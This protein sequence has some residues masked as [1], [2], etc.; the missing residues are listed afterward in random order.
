MGE[1]DPNL[2][3][4]GEALY[5]AGDQKRGIPAW[6]ACHGPTGAGNGPANFPKV[7]GQNPDHVIAALKEYQVGNRQQ[8]MMV[9]ISQKLN[10]KD[11]QAVASYIYGL[12]PAG[13]KLPQETTTAAAGTPTSTNGAAAGTASTTS[14]APTSATTSKGSTTK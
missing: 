8:D 13:M 3:K 9:D 11:M 6:M 4:Q 2:V 10:D 5:K 1:A 12:Y 14:A 7:A